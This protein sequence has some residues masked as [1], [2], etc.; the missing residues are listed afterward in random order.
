MYQPLWFSKMFEKYRKSIPTPYSLNMKMFAKIRMKI[1]SAV[2][3]STTHY[4]LEVLNLHLKV[5][6][7]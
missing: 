3:I 1:K 2:S 6:E 7:F 4:N 5:L